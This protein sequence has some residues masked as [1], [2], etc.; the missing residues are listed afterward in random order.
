[1][2]FSLWSQGKIFLIG[3]SSGSLREDN[4]EVTQLKQG[5]REVIPNQR[6]IGKKALAELGMVTETPQF[7]E[8]EGYTKGPSQEVTA[9]ILTR[10]LES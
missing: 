1:M 9:T 2:K 7:L 4:R 5:P 6:F 8:K 3:L 10:N